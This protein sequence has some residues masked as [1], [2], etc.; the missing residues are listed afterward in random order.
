MQQKQQTLSQLTKQKHGDKF[1]FT[2][3]D[4]EKMDRG[5]Q[6]M[7]ERVKLDRGYNNTKV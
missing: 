1:L 5:Q 6:T 2:L 3:S 7:D 4:H